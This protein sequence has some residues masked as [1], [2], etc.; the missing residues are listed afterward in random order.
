MRILPA[1]MSAVLLASTLIVAQHPEVAHAQLREIPRLKLDPP[2]GGSVVGVEVFY[3]TTV[4]VIGYGFTPGT[5]VAITVAGTP[6]LPPADALTVDDYGTFDYPI[7]FW[8]PATAGPFYAEARSNVTRSEAAGAYYD[9]PCPE[10]NPT[11]VLTLTPTCGDPGTPVRI[12]VK[13]S[14][15]YDQYTKALVV[16]DYDWDPYATNPPAPYAQ[17]DSFNSS[18]GTF[19][20]DVGFTPP[21]ADVFR[22]SVIVYFASTNLDSVSLGRPFTLSAFFNAPCPV[23]KVNPY[24]EFEGSP[25]SRY[26]LT[27]NGQGFLPT[28]PLNITYDPVGV[29]Q[30]YIWDYTVNDDGT[31]GPIDIA[32]FPRVGPIDIVVR[33]YEYHNDSPEVVLEAR[34][35][36][37]VPC[38]PVPITV[39]PTCNS[40]Q[41]LSDAPHT[42]SLK[43]SGSPFQTGPYPVT[44][45]FDPTGP[46]LEGD[47]VKSATVYPDENGFAE[48]RLL[49]S[50]RPAGPYTVY[51]RQ[52][53]GDVVLEGSANFNSPC[54]TRTPVVSVD[55]PCVDRQAGDGT[56]DITISGRRFIRGLVDISFD[57][58]STNQTATERTKDDGSFS[59]PMRVTALKPGTYT[60]RVQQTDSNK[61]VLDEGTS[62]FA[63]ACGNGPPP[64]LTITPGSATPGFVV[65]V[66]GQNLPT[67]ATFYLYWD[68]GIGRSTPIRVDTDATGTFEKQV[69]IFRHDF[70]GSRTMTIGSSIDLLDPQPIPDVSATLLV[71]PGNGTP[72]A[73]NLFGGSSGPGE[74]IVNRR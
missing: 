53:V 34:V 26:N 4:T 17:T 64:S 39:D 1:V 72:P 46:E 58:D 32:P 45:T 29:P 48:A 33:Q 73:Y 27:L 43:A 49:V 37:N 62:T 28:G 31:W 67:L 23:L 21:R 13:G 55:P 69:L 38:G 57:P 25:P 70:M 7:Q 59:H 24:C 60:V 40:P 35:T 51:A 19:E 63:I 61:V 30:V 74:P 3:P 6:A 54:T 66:V 14:N 47:E 41:F 52:E 12:V 71:V 50:A 44:F 16:T 18:G 65:L 10:T 2:C 56:Y 42:W 9:A 22:V 5:T 68:H 20:Q 15:F 36:L 11:P 8:Q